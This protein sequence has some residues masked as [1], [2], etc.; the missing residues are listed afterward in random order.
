MTA[1]RVHVDSSAGTVP[2]GTARISRVRGVETTEFTY[3]DGFLSGPGWEISPDLPLHVR[4]SVIEGLPGALDDSAPELWGRNLITRRLAAQARDAGHIAPTPTEVDYLLGVN[5]LTRQ[6]A[7]RFCLGDDQ[8][9]LA[10]SA[11]VP[12]LLE[13][14]MLLEAT[15]QV[16]RGNDADEAVAMLLAA[17]SGSLGGARPKA[18]VTDGTTLH[19]AK[20]PKHDD[21]WDVMRWEAVALDLA[22]ECGLRTPAYQLIEV[23]R[24]PVLLVERF[25]RDGDR[26]IPYLSARSLIGARSGGS[27]DY[28]E[29][30]EGL[31]DHGSD[32]SAD[33]VE[34]W[35]RIAF[36]V[37]INNTD[38]H[39]RNHAVLRTGGGWM[40]SPIFDVNPDPRPAA[41]RVTSIAGA[42]AAE[43]CRRALFAAAPSFGLE[44]ADAE[45]LWRDLLDVTVRWRDFAIRNGITD[46]ARDEFA[47][48]LDRWSA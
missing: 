46:A 12:R 33:L 19:I 36:S 27:C 17:G 25:D 13:L 8:S 32:V 10:A 44:P 35:R 31:T 21:P 22:A 6:G 15:R 5:D 30:V 9:F 7:L 42:N 26:R 11:G 24:Y 23:G 4:G 18:S 34:L 2:V 29:L 37:A 41:R 45:Q 43:A 16:A 48:V 28:L 39:M 38:D 1:I 14:E 20:F 3:D 47:P 40:L